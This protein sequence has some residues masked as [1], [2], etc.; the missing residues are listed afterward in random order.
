MADVSGEGAE[1]FEN[2]DIILWSVD[3][4]DWAMRSP[5]EIAEYVLNNTKSG[6][7]ILMHDYIGKDS[8][9]PEALELMIPQ[10]IEKGYVSCGKFVNV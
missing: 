7:I 10:L 2:Y 5:G 9:T 1:L 6:D 3:T 4:M 8:P